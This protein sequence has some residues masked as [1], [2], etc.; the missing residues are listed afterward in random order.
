MNLCQYTYTS[1]KI[2][3]WSMLLG[4]HCWHYYPG[5]CLNIKTV[6]PSMGNPMLTHWPH[7]RFRWHFRW[8]I[9]MLILVI[10]YWNC[11]QMNVTGSYWW[12]V[13]IGS[14]N[15]LVPDGTKPLPEPMLTQIYVAKWYHKAFSVMA[16]LTSFSPL[17]Q[18]SKLSHGTRPTSGRPFANA[19]QS[20]FGK[21]HLKFLC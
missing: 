2:E 3:Q 14:G 11:H 20:A 8:V 18:K 1:N 7:G 15:G 21:L 16:E 19:G 12:Q 6:F 9:F 5:P 4:G 10:D 17:T 13:N